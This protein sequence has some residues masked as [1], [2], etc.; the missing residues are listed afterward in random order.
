MPLKILLLHLHNSL[1]MQQTLF[2]LLIPLPLI[3]CPFHPLFSSFSFAY[4]AEATATPADRCSANMSAKLVRYAIILVETAFVSLHYPISQH[5]ATSPANLPPLQSIYT[6]EWVS[7]Y[8]RQDSP[9]CRDC[10]LRTTTR[11]KRT[12][13]QT[14]N[15]VNYGTNQEF[16]R[17][18]LQILILCFY[19]MG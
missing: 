12:N 18:H 3:G 16:D 17:M 7:S 15:N 19:L 1:V 6:W 10:P 5:S 2:I 14:I 8:R 13:R 4:G 9:W 11:K